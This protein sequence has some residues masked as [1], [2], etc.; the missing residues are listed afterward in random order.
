VEFGDRALPVSRG[1]LDIWLAQET[2]H[3]GAEWQ[4]GLF[5]K[6]EGFVERDALEW[7]IGRVVR[8]A[9][10][11]RAAFFES[12]G[13]VLQSAIDYADVELTFFDLGGSRHAVQEA[14]EIASSIQRT[15]MPF[16]G[17]LFKFLLF[18]TRADEFYLFVCCHHIVIDGF[19]LALVCQ[20]IASVYSAIVSGA[21]VAPSIFGSLQDLL[22][23]ESEYEASKDYLD[24]QAYWT[25][26]LPAISEPRYRLPEASGESD[27]YRSSGPVR[28]D[29]VVLRRVEQLCQLWNMPRSSV[30]TAAC[31]LLVRGWCTTG[32]EV[33][34]DFPVSRPDRGHQHQPR[35]RPRRGRPI[36]STHGGRV[37]SAAASN[38]HFSAGSSS[39]PDPQDRHRRTAV[40]HSSRRWG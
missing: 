28:L 29:P 40:L 11:V 34:L 19:G 7:A 16:T 39:G 15:S 30:I 20:R 2:G 25:A 38:H 4:L 35:H 12:D 32:Q 18:Q 6:I 27:P 23:C 5:V 14:R 13:Q 17:Q 24:D 1:Q 37:E 36:R 31:A 3:S 9:E 26:N 22:D 8:E 21:P 33:V 10:A